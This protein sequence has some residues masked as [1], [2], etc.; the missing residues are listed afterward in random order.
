LIPAGYG[1]V[2][3]QRSL[4]LTPNEIALRRE[5]LKIADVRRTRW[6]LGEPKPGAKQHALA[7]RDFRI[8]RSVPGNM[9]SS[10]FKVRK[11]EASARMTA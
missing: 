3:P 10:S 2:D 1:G 5:N 6:R 7:P 9:A 4:G 11:F 8:R